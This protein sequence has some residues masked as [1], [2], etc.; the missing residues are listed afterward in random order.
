MAFGSTVPQRPLNPN[1]SGPH[2]YAPLLG[3]QSIPTFEND[4]CKWHLSS[5]DRVDRTYKLHIGGKQVRP[6][7]PYV[8]SI[9]DTQGRTIGQVPEGNRKD[10]RNAVE[11]AHNAFPGWSLRAAHNRAQIVYYLCVRWPMASHMYFIGVVAVLRTSRY[12][13]RSLRRCC[14]R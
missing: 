14:P 5:R 1:K 8:R 9:T 3:G 11:A 7:A 6:D 2:S 12:G 13:A 10:L 4:I